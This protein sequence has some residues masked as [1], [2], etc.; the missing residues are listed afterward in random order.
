MRSHDVLRAEGGDEGETREQRN[1]WHHV[2]LLEHRDRR[3]YQI[4]S[5]KRSFSSFFLYFIHYLHHVADDAVLFLRVSFFEH[6]EPI[7]F[8]G[9]PI[10]FVIFFLFDY[11]VIDLMSLKFWGL[12][13]II[14]LGLVAHR[15][16]ERSKLSSTSAPIL[17]GQS[18]PQ[19]DA[20][21]RAECQ[22]IH[23]IQRRYLAADGTL[24]WRWLQIGCA[25]RKKERKRKGVVAET[26]AFFYLRYIVRGPSI[27]SVHTISCR[28]S[29]SLK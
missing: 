2:P 6:S 27:D 21:K 18:D 15:E 17:K 10:R 9:I 29:C 8:D 12:W 23:A 25:Y 26:R 20:N 28:C 14:A 1:Y 13:G 4:A 11:L 16:P 24:R 5:L 19:S 22:Q 3:K 7:S